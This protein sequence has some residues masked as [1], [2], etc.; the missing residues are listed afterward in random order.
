MIAR[1]TALIIFIQ[2]LNGLLGYVGLKFIAIYMQPWEYGVIGFAYGFV[3]LFSILGNLG[4][5][6]AH[7]KRIS[8]G[9]CL[10]KCIATY[11]LT[12]TVLAGLVACSVIL[13]IAIW[14]YVLN[15]GFE[16]PLHEQVVNIVRVTMIFFCSI[17]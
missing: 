12:K 16:T 13:S 9:K 10:G 7:V 15:R 5:N 3:S 8:E 4:F 1:K 11:A 17:L 2:L 14:K 6:S